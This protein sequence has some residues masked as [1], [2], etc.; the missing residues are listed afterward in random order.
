MASLG[1]DAS[2]ASSNGNG[3]GAERKNTAVSFGFTKTVS[4]FKS[5]ASGAIVN[6]EEKD[7][8]T[9]I[10]G[11]EPRRYVRMLTAS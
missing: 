9:G 8:L 5:S 7:Y 1:E 4:K 6:S 10:D 11:N 3:E 2:A